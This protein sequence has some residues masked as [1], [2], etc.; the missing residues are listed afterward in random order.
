MRIL[1][2]ILSKP[3][4]PAQQTDDALLA[5]VAQGDMKA[6][7][8]IHRRYFPKLMHFAKRITDSREA[9]EEVANDTLMT[10]WR[11][12]GRFEGRSKPSTW[13]FGIAYRMALKQRQKLGKRKNDVELDETMIGAEGDAAEAVIRETDLAKALERLTPELRATV[14]LTYFSG[15]LYTEIAEIMECPVGTVKTRMMTA[16]RRLRDILSDEA[17]AIG[18]NAVA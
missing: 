15:L 12:A 1:R 9:A 14:E 13:M 10:V 16:R 11:T 17:Y 7:E 4:G 18:E 6:F 2:P 8:Q 3:G 5:A